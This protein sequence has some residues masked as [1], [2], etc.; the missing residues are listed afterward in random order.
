MHAVVPGGG[1]ALVG[2]R[3]KEATAPAGRPCGGYLVDAITLR[4][5]FREHFIKGL[6]RLFSKAELKLEGEF[7]YL[8]NAEQQEALLSELQS[9][10]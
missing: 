7:S 9:V 6:R 10:E 3:W 2:G 4:Q 1:P 5:T 8:Q